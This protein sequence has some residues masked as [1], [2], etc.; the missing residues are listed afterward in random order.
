[1][2]DIPETPATPANEVDRKRIMRSR[3]VVLGV[4]LAAWVVLIFAI[5]I[6]KMV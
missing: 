1:M 5:S 6:V 4:L 2:A 3:N